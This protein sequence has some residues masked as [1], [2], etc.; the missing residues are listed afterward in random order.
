MVI[1]HGPPGKENAKFAVDVN[2]E[3][4]VGSWGWSS[5]SGGRRKEG[6]GREAGAGRALGPFLAHCIRL[7]P[8]PTRMACIGQRWMPPL[9][10]R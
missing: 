6:R 4:G 8:N 9:C 5:V 1:P 10:T 2:G 3:A 7:F